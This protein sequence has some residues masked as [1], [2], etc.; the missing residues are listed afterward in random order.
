MADV[1]V[2][3]KNAYNPMMLAAGRRQRPQPG[4][5]DTICQPTDVRPWFRK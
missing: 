5:D 2:K 4:A 1:V 3:D